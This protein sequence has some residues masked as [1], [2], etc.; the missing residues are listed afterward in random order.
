VDERFETFTVRGFRLDRPPEVSPP[1]LV[2]ALRP[3]MLRLGASEADGVVTNC[4]AAADVPRVV[5]EL[6]PNGASAE[7]AAR[8][9][10]CPTEDAG[11]A[12]KLG[13]RL[14]STYLS[15]PVYAEF[16]RWL[17]RGPLL[18]PMWRA[19]NAGDR[20]GA[21]AA[22]PDEVVDALVVHGTP[23]QCRAHLRRY[24]DGGVTTAVIALLPTPEAM[25]P[26]GALPAGERALE[27]LAPGDAILL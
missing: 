1:I 25:A 24:L 14:I 21:N 22:I 11:H 2:A 18:E 15:V 16:H 13:R 5:A 23:E 19:W 12:R 6:G 27:T 10:V 3:G 4:L 17:G 7:V 26:G 9:F 8:I 20:K